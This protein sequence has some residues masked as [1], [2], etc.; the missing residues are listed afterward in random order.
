LHP[1][2]FPHDF[3]WKT[4]FPDLS[5]REEFLLASATEESH[6]FAGGESGFDFFVRRARVEIMVMSA[7]V[8]GTGFVE[9]PGE[10]ITAV[11]SH[12]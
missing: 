10:E 2:L 4:P 1:T 9:C 7:K 8:S 11:S 12:K 6:G 5:L 3:T